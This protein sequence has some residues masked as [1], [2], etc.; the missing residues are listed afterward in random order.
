M[1]FF[2]YYSQLILATHHSHQSRK[3][4]KLWTPSWVLRRWLNLPPK[5]WFHKQSSLF[6][7]LLEQ[8]NPSHGIGRRERKGWVAS[9]EALQVHGVPERNPLS[10]PHRQKY[11]TFQVHL[12]LHLLSLLR[13]RLRSSHRYFMVQFPLTLFSL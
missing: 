7:F 11:T 10:C 3:F 9:T 8:T 4:L 13:L 1:K 6:L 12:P 5:P 2:F